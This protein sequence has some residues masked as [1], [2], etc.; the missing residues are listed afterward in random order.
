LVL[1]ETTE[2]PEGIERG[3][4]KLIGMN[5]EN[6][7]LNVTRLLTDESYYLSMSKAGN[8]YGD[9]RAAQRIIKGIQY[10][11]KLGEKPDEFT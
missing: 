8:P 6:I 4:A 5:R 7:I 2:R 1:R 11:F 10:F 3:V 9:G